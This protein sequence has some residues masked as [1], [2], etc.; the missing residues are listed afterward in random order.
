MKYTVFANRLN[1][2][3]K[4]YRRYAKKANAIGLETSM[5][6]VKKYPKKIAVYENDHVNKVTARVGYTVMEVAD[7]EINFPE[8]KL[9]NYNVIAVLEHTDNGNTVYPCTEEEVPTKYFT[10]KGVCEHCNTNHKRVKTIVLKDTEGNYK[11]VGRACLK[12]YTGVDDIDLVSAYEALNAITIDADA[13]NGWYGIAPKNDYTETNVYLAKCIHLIKKEG[14]VKDVT[15]YDACKIKAEE[16]TKEDYNDADTVINYF[17]DIET[18]DTFI[19]NI[20]VAVNNEYIDKVNGFIAYAYVAYTKAIEKEAKYKADEVIEYYG[21]VGD[22]FKNIKVTAKV[23]T[24]YE[25]IYGTTNIIEFRDNNNHIYIWKTSNN[26]TCNNDG[27]WT[28][29]ITGTVK[30]HNEYKGIKQTVVTRVKAIKDEPEVTITFD[31]KAIW[32]ALEQIS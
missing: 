13:D 24:H 25:T 32:K 26:I 17:K 1:D 7:V 19:N 21:N 8:Y 20:K 28:G 31:E 6:V 9:G 23:L 5:E 3:E 10:A 16:I 2:L 30:A 27:T 15:K 22:K 4:A 14:Y 11:Q 12:E 29:T 18:T